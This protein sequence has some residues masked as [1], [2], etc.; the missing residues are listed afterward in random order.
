MEFWNQLVLQQSLSQV[1]LLARN[2]VGTIAKN[3]LILFLNLI[4]L[5]INS[6]TY[7]SFT[8][9]DLFI[10]YFLHSKTSKM[11]FRDNYAGMHS[12][13]ITSFPYVP[14]ISGK[15]ILSMLIIL[16]ILNTGITPCAN[17]Q[18]AMIYRNVQN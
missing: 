2:N 5:K 11:T 1:S 8:L 3:S 16:E 10:H 9:E 7:D 12:M 13:C 4:S 15:I 17:S 6:L 14:N 18:E